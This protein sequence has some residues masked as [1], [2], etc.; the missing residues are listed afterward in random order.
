MSNTSGGGPLSAIIVG[1]G[2]RSFTDLNTGGDT[3]G[4]LGGHGGGDQRLVEDFVSSLRGGAPSISCTS[5]QDSISGHLAVFRADLAR[6][7]GCGV[8]MERQI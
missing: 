4:A 6:E 5:I 7:R 3:T 2:H 8:S 1:A